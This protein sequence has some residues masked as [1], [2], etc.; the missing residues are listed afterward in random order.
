M[1][2]PVPDAQEVTEFK[3]IYKEK[4]GIDLP[5]DEAYDLALRFLHFYFFATTPPPGK[6]TH[7][8][9]KQEK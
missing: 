5:D 4:R 6:V 7:E 2:L 3:R 8:E 1:N 9:K